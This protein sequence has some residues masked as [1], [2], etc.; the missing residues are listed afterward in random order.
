LPKVFDRRHRWPFNGPR[1]GPG[2][3]D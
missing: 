2:K 1:S 3:V